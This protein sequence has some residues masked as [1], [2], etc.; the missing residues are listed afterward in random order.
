MTMLQAFAAEEGKPIPPTP[1][2]IATEILAQG[3]LPARL[4][5]PRPDG[6]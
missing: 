6:R 3:M 1:V 2:T 5:K 4:P